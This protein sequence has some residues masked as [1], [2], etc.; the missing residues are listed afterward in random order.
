MM[1]E[2]YPSP[3]TGNS[4]CNHKAAP[5]PIPVMMARTVTDLMVVAPMADLEWNGTQITRSIESAILSAAR[6]S[7]H[8]IAGEA[9]KKTPVERGILRG[10]AKVTDNGTD[11]S[12]V[13]YNT[14]Y[15]ARQH[16]EV[17]WAHPGGGEA[18]FLEKA[19]IENAGKVADL[20][21][22]EIRK[23]LGL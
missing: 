10:T 19:S 5:H 14:K 9:I 1:P 18:K 21:A 23:G 13:S 7:A 22:E 8:L 17:G 6:G 3:R 16:E 4:P 2:T 11:T 12:A 20:V 15:A